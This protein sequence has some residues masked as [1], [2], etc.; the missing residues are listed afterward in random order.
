MYKQIAQ[1]HSAGCLMIVRHSENNVE[2]LGTGFLCHS[3][4]YILTCAHTI[5]LTDKISA[6]P[7]L[8]INQFNPSTLTRVNVIPVSVAQ[9]DAQNDVALL[10]FSSPQTVSVPDKLFGQDDAVF[11]GA[12]VCYM[13]FPFGHSGLH[14]LK[15]SGSLISAKVIST[16]GTKQFQFDAM[17]H[18]GNS[19]GPLIELA[20]GQIIGVVVGRFS[21]TGSGGGIRIGNHPL[22]TE[23]TISYATC[24]GYGRAL[25]QN[26]GLNG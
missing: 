10:K 7:T 18:E 20:T 3:K 22:G 15:V 12:S 14:S 6:V 23:S 11:V 1:R 4:G 26:E 19:G 24:I 25:L 5:S 9:Y 21:P 13:G 16:A 8:P 17:V 2:F